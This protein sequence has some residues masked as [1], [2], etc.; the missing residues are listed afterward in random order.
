VGRPPPTKSDPVE[1]DPMIA[2]NADRGKV[3]GTEQ[4]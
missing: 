2:R 3:G 1:S 4:V